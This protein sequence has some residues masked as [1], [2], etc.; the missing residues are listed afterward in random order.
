MVLQAVSSR[1]LAL[2]T[3]KKHYLHPVMWE[4]SPFCGIFHHLQLFLV[5]W[6]ISERAHKYSIVLVTIGKPKNYN[7]NTD[8]QLF[9]L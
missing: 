7:A 1:I 2:L 6:A 5:V 4:Q 8:S 3:K 9:F